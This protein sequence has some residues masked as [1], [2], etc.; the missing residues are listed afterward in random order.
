MSKDATSR[1]WYREPYVWLLITFPLAAVIGGI[2]TIVLAIKSDDGLVVDDYYKQGLEINRKLERDQKAKDLALRVTLQY[3]ADLPKV[4][5]V[6][7]ARDDFQYPQ[8]L[9][10]SFLNASRNNLDRKLE[11][12]KNA[13]N[14]YT[15]SNPGL[16]KGKWHVLVEQDDWRVLEV[17]HVP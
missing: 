4:R 11:F 1:P 2:I 7:N 14:M 16:V 12:T 15:A 5:V 17:L 3:G 10:V 9:Q 6:L 13:D 8:S